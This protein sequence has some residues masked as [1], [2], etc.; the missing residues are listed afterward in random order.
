M[1]GCTRWPLAQLPK[2]RAKLAGYFGEL[3]T[4]L[5]IWGWDFV[6]P[7]PSFWL[8]AL[9]LNRQEKRAAL[10]KWF[11]HVGC[12]GNC[13]LSHYIRWTFS[14]NGLVGFCFFFA[15][16]ATSSQRLRWKDRTREREQR[17]WLRARTSRTLRLSRSYLLASNFRGKAVP[18]GL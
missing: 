7:R 13:K 3:A 5:S 1:T 11:V 16:P 8:P 12:H 6:R 10:A 4:A 18:R 14:L 9:R 2:P 17:M 15:L